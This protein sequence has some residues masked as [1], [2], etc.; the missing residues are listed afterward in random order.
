M[1]NLIGP[2]RSRVNFYSRILFIGSGPCLSAT[3]GISM[4][5][6]VIISMATSLNE[7]VGESKL[8]QVDGIK[9]SHK[10]SMVDMGHES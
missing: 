6:L 10:D 4:I 5:P 9:K 8:L 2:F 7:Q 1:T 3:P